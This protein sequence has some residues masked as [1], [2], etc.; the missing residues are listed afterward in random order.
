M[1]RTTTRTFLTFVYREFRRQN[2]W[3]LARDLQVA[4]RDKGN[5]RRIASEIGTELVV[6]GE[7]I[8]GR[9]FLRLAGLARCP[10]AKDDIATLLAVVRLIAEAVISGSRAPVTS[11][12]IK[13]DLGLDDAA[14]RR[15]GHIMYNE[16]GPWS[17]GTWKPD[18]SA[19]AVNPRD[20]AV[21]YEKVLTL[22][23]YQ[24]AN[25]RVTADA[26]ATSTALHGDLRQK[27]RT[28]KGRAAAK[29]AGKQKRRVRSATNLRTV[30][31]Q[32]RV[33]KLR[34]EG[35][36]G[37]VYEV[38]DE[39]GTQFAAK[40]LFPDKATREKRKRFSNE[41]RF[42][43][44]NQHPAIVTVLD[45]GVLLERGQGLPF[46]IMRLYDG[47]LRTLMN[48]GIPPDRVLPYF[49]HILDGVEAAHLQGVLHRDLKPENIFFDKPADRLLVGDFGIASFAEEDLF[50]A[51]ETN[52][53]ARL[54]NFVYAAPE[55]RQRGGT[56]GNRADIYALGLILNE[57]FTGQVA[58]GTAYTTIAHKA[59]QYGYLDP[60]VERM[61]RNDLSERPAS[62][63]EV[64]GEL[65]VRGNTFVERQKL[66]QLRNTV[67]PL[68]DVDDPLVTTPVVITGT[69]YRNGQLIFRLNPVPT[70]Q[71][72]TIFH[73]ITGVSFYPGR[74]PTTVN[75]SSDH[76]LLRADEHD[77]A[78]TKQM[79]V[80][81]LET[82]NA[83]YKAWKIRMARD[84]SSHEDA[85]NRQRIANEEERDRVLRRLGERL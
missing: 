39:D 48:G 47:T 73:N 63:D 43:S 76:A 25:A 74:E 46:Y 34:G 41:L 54:A 66:D 31:N 84:K 27:V 10:D 9:C 40:I 64:K 69:D 50:T 5:V 80:Q 4:L 6:C 70:T 51:V 38:E 11:E 17:G 49:A 42:C 26:I 14:L 75:F 52:E 28:P 30:L 33:G 12:T 72:I 61:L 81:W 44:K 29:H 13:E 58:Q 57:M 71:W 62:I 78:M 8:E 22:D 36:A 35:G 37:R 15:L 1:P 23:D 55:Q 21:F 77:A 20:E 85:A 16:S 67:I 19:F 7:G 60:L 24:N 53:H 18:G 45:S 56:V 3:P 68:G 2:N 32:Y 82:A 83:D 65:R 79:F 59:P